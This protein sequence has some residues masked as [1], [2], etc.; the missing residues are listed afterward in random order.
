MAQIKRSLLKGHAETSI[1]DAYRIIRTN[2]YADRADEEKLKTIM[3][4]SALPGEGKST[5]A[6]NTAISYAQLGKRVI[7]LDCNLYRPMQDRLIN[8]FRRNDSNFKGLGIGDYL[9]KS[10]PVD[11][12]DEIISD[13]D[14]KNLWLIASGYL[15]LKPTELLGSLEMEKALD[16]LKTKADI[17]IVDT[18]AVAFATDACVLAAK[19]DGIIMVING[20][21]SRPETVYKAQ[22][23]LLKAK[24]Q[25]LG[26]I[27]NRVKSTDG[28]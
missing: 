4:T 7:L 19:M 17:I 27:L 20:N 25:L 14:T 5:I 16:Y 10:L 22:Q 13:T 21:M 15:P 12:I 8:R 3:F 11:T 9:G 18:P 28:Y 23:A 24:G 2:I 6:A 26:V 1:A